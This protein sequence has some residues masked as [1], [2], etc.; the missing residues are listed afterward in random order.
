M[1]N[2]KKTIITFILSLSF[3][4]LTPDT[5][6]S[7][8]RISS[9]I[10]VYFTW[11]TDHFRIHYPAGSEQLAESLAGYAEEL[12]QK[13]GPGYDVDKSIV[14]VSLV[15]ENDTVNAF[16][17]PFGYNQVVLFVNNPPVGP[18]GGS[19]WSYYDDWVKELFLHEYTH[20]LTT[21]Y[22]KSTFRGFMKF[23]TG[24]TPNVIAPHG[25]T[26]GISVYEE[27]KAG[28]GRNNDPVTEMIIRT[29]VNHDA[30]PD[31]GELMNGS[32]RWPQ[33]SIYYL[34]GGAINEFMRN[35]YDENAIRD[36]WQGPIIPLF[37]D[38]AMRNAGMFGYFIVYKEFYNDLI[39]KYKAQNESL[40]NA[41]LTPF[42]KL[43]DSGGNKSFLFLEE[44]RP[45]YF[46]SRTSSIPGIYKLDNNDEKRIRK[47][48]SV[49]GL[50][51]ASGRR[52]FSE[53]YFKY[54]GFGFQY[55][56][57]NGNRN[58][59]L[60]RWLP[61]R[62]ISFPSLS[63]DGKVLYFIEREGGEKI[64]RTLRFDEDDNPVA[65][66]D[67]LRVNH[68]GILQYAAASHDGSRVAVLVRNGIEG[69]GDLIVCEDKTEN[70]E[71]RKRLSGD[72]AIIH[73]R[74]SKDDESLYFSADPD[75]VFN[76]YSF[77]LKTNGIRRLT[78]TGGGFFY[79]APG[80]DGLY[81]LSYD[82]DGYDVVRFNYND[83]MSEPA[84]NLVA[85]DTLYSP[86][87]LF[88]D[89]T[90]RDSGIK[91]HVHPYNGILNMKFYWI[92]LLNIGFL[93][94]YSF[95]NAGI[96]GHDPLNRHS[97]T[98]AGGISGYGPEVYAQ[99]GYSRFNTSIYLSY[100]SNFFG[101]K[102]DCFFRDRGIYEGILCD[103]I[104]P[105]IESSSGY[106]SYNKEHRYFSL[107]I[108]AGGVHKK[109]R[110]ADRL[111][112]YTYD[113]KDVNLSGPSGYLMIGQTHYYPTSISAEH[114]W[115][116]FASGEYFDPGGS[117]VSDKAGHKESV[118]F[119]EVTGGL[120]FYLPSFFK[121]HVNYFSTTGYSSTG[122]DRDIVRGNLALF[123][124]GL[125][126]S[127]A[128]S[129]RV[130]AV[131]TYEY[132]LPVAWFSRIV[133]RG[134]SEFMVNQVDL[135][136]YY[137]RGVSFFRSEK[138]GAYAS[139]YGIRVNLGGHL[140]YIPSPFQ[141]TISAGKGTGPS[142]EIVGSILLTIGYPGSGSFHER[143]LRRDSAT[144]NYKPL[145]K[146]ARMFQTGRS[147][148]NNYLN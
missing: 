124:R 91:D 7:Q 92:G 104:N 138:D 89:L 51:S 34:Y 141:L 46:Q 60:S 30:L 107:Q 114:G 26:E 139:G 1:Q 131:G 50:A 28:H 144:E 126:P 147:D 73:L 56:L 16:A 109:I 115:R 127:F 118:D 86:D 72:S 11:Q 53:E 106:L 44:G 140:L 20:I 66:R 63:A 82:V 9:G 130:A 32:H 55:E 61:G 62:R 40:K 96:A 69:R 94:G 2:M 121:N 76:L 19:G 142:G 70:F 68:R 95:I 133:G 18:L 79:P 49:R 37:L 83:L 77:H 101:S 135:A 123:V 33:G 137:D 71:C 10:P 3:L 31:Q 128:P 24:V 21:G 97:F 110:D 112:S 52:V 15:L 74:F 93:P 35:R 100:F 45:V 57:Y 146:K 8:N 4:L 148:R 88:S 108:L 29:A 22:T 87:S 41:G 17:T 59:L 38:E 117:F 111:V 122:P 75:R 6:L 132:R 136:F 81:A 5:L 102:P 13:L 12:R 103:K 85:E 42:E 143:D 39:K 36:Y 90:S 116:F 67:V 47:V 27:S 14:N 105:Q 58:L 54:P 120:S 25:M 145:L 48:Y 43:T 65:Q 80:D 119:G 78:G 113:H 134:D 64:L 23:L 84:D 125:N 129:N 99:Y 98:L